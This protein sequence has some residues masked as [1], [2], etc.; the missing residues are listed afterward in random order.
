[1]LDHSHDK[2]LFAIVKGWHF[3]NDIYR[4]VVVRFTHCIFFIN[5][6]T[7]YNIWY[8][9]QQSRN[10]KKFYTRVGTLHLL[11]YQKYFGNWLHIWHLKMLVFQPQNKNISCEF[12]KIHLNGLYHLINMYSYIDITISVSSDY[13]FM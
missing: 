6:I 11:T 3:S 1:M 13:F 10:C 9:V 2:I 7:V 4:Y 12:H 8:Y 5:V